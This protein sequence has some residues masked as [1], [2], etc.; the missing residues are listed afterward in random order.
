M[1]LFWRYGEMWDGEV[2]VVCRAGA[3]Q[4]NVGVRNVERGRCFYL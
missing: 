3:S 2:N 1:V 4:P